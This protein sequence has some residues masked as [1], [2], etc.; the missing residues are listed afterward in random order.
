[1]AWLIIYGAGYAGS[2][3]VDTNPLLCRIICWFH[4]LWPTFSTRLANQL[5]VLSQK[6]QPTDS[7]HIRILVYTYVCVQIQIISKLFITLRCVFYFEL[8]NPVNF[9]A[10]PPDSTSRQQSAN[11]DHTHIQRSCTHR[12]D[13]LCRSDVES[14][15]SWDE[16]P[17]S[18]AAY[19]RF[20]FSREQIELRYYGEFR[21][22]MSLWH[23][24]EYSG[25]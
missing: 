21:C 14:G 12:V 20:Y 22:R 16:N 25:N 2:E 15:S 7:L 17:A 5:H 19:V 10:D 1:M 8:C 6:V 3:V 11:R 18:R 4:L 9:R 24:S 23:I 13:A